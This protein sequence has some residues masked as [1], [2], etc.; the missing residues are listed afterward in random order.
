MQHT[1]VVLV[2][3]KPGVANR[4]S[5]IFRRRGFNMVSLTVSPTEKTGISRFTI[6]MDSDKREAYRLKSYLYKLVNVLRVDDLTDKA[7]VNRDMALI[8]IHANANNRTEIMQL[9]EV[10]RARVVDVANEALIVE[11]TGT[12]D[13]IDGFIEVLRPYGIIEMAASGAVALMR[14]PVSVYSVE[15]EAV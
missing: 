14:G 13:K 15:G 6:V 11:I 12:Q 4:I 8:K 7:N 1:F 5:S 10:F 9:V 3:D 2:E